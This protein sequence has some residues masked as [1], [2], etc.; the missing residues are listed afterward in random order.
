MLSGVGDR[1]QLESHGIDVKAHLP[2]VGQNLQDHLD[3]YVQYAC[4]QPVTLF[5]ASWRFPHNM[6]RYGAEWFMGLYGKAST[7][8]LESG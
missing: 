4:K 3:L 1:A 8:H 2:G 7:S 6:I 5:T